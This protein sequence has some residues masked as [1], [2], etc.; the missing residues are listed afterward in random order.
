MKSFMTSKN[1]LLPT[2]HRI[3]S[4]PSQSKPQSHSPELTSQR[5]S[6]KTGSAENG[7]IL[8]EHRSPKRVVV[9]KSNSSNNCH[10]QFVP[11]ATST[12]NGVLP[13]NGRRNMTSSG[14]VGEH[15]E[16]Y[17]LQQRDCISSGDYLQYDCV[18]SNV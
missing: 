17:V 12:P 16:E 3:P 14:S 8:R 13:S 6:S 5:Q 18:D 10:V 11:A 9:A 4:H 15:F 2:G 1:R 7:G